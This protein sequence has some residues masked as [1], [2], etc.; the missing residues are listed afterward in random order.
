MAALGSKHATKTLTPHHALL[1]KLIC[2]CVATL[3]CREVNR[4]GLE[5]LYRILLE[6]SAPELIAVLRHITGG[7]RV[8]ASAAA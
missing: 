8:N 7:G 6:D 1:F 2:T 4:G 3:S 5:G